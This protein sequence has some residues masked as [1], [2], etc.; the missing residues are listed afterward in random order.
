MS[1]SAPVIAYIHPGGFYIF[2]GN[3]D[4]F[5][6]DYLL[7]HAV[8]LVTFNYRLGFAGFASPGDARAAGNAALH[9]Q[10]LVLLWIAQNIALFGGDPRRVTL[11]GSSAGAM[12]VAVHLA[13]RQDAASALFHRAIVMSGGI[14]PQL[15]LPSDQHELLRRQAVMLKCATGVDDFECVRRAPVDQL[16][17]SVYRMF[18]Y[19]R[20]NPIFVWLPVVDGVLVRSAHLLPAIGKKPNVPLLTGTTADELSTSA[21]QILN[22][23]A[24]TAAWLR[25]F[26]RVAPIAL[27][28]ERDTDESHRLSDRIWR[29]YFSGGLEFGNLS[30]C[31]SDAVINF[32]VERLAEL[33][34]RRSPVYR[35]RF[36]YRGEYTNFPAPA[37]RPTVVEHCDEL[38]YLFTSK[39][40]PRI[41]ADDGRGAGMVRR[42]TAMVASFARDGYV[43]GVTG[44]AK[45]WKM[46][47]QFWGITAEFFAFI[48]EACSE[49]KHDLQ[50]KVMD[51]CAGFY[52]NVKA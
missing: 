10:R 12:S 47:H 15:R 3:T 31:F 40:W 26:R 27:H 32:P 23:G 35:Y 25:D 20:D 48:R 22:D 24:Q 45:G 29:H 44:Q 18:E 33:V 19:G 4:H 34:A 38:Q 41:A 9:D 1:A 5:G 50:L 8:V 21:E 43:H 16:A 2:S 36:A 7:D 46:F 42:M 28:Y 30:A 14:L 52:V 6:P 37:A 17:A 13:D 11:M 49:D 39:N 51:Y